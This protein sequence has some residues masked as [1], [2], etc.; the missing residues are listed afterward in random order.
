M[1]SR[2]AKG[3]V[4]GEEG[5]REGHWVYREKGSGGFIYRKIMKLLYRGWIIEG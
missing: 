5:K 1:N 2:M 3:G 4:K